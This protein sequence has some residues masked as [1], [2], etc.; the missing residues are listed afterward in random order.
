MMKFIGL[1]IYS[2]ETE[3]G[4][5]GS[6]HVNGMTEREKVAYYN[7]VMFKYKIIKWRMKISYI[8]LVK[9]MTVKELIL[10]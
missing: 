10:K 8:A 1:L 3:D 4:I 6:A 9:Q 5:K 2:I 7:K